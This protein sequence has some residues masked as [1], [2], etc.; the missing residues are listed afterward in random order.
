MYKKSTLHREQEGLVSIVVTMIIMIVLTL[1]VTGFAQLARREQRESLDRQLSTQA[2]YAAESGINDARRMLKQTPYNNGTTN[3]TMCDRQYAVDPDPKVEATGNVQYTCLLIKQDLKDLKFQNVQ[4]NKST[5]VPINPVVNAGSF[6]SLKISWQNKTGANNIRGGTGF[7]PASG[8]GAWGTDNVSVLR[9]DL[10]PAG[11]N[12]TADS[13]KSGLYTAFL[14]PTSGGGT[15]SYGVSNTGKNAGI[16][17]NANCTTPAAKKCSVKISGLGIYSSYFLRLRALYNVADVNVCADSCDGNTTLNKAQAEL[18]STGR[19]NDVLK[20]IQARV[21][22]VPDYNGASSIPEFALDSMDNVC[23]VL[24][25]YPK[26]N[27]LGGTDSC[28][29]Y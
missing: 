24:S 1:V 22:I 2:F 21:S 5:V 25:V 13:M 10:V 26:F 27:G 12:F 3:K 16:I 4:T 15:D 6:D 11:A 9:V 28:S 20:R 18:D 14:Y 19:A 8:P 17:V 29:P 7:P 23:K